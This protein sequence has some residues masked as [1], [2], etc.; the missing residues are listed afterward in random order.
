[1]TIGQTP[2]DDVIA[3]M[4]SVLE[5]TIEIVERGALDGL[6]REAIEDACEPSQGTLLVTRLRGGVEVR[7]REG[8]VTPKLQQCVTS[9][10]KRVDLI[11]VLCTGDFPPLQSDLPVLYP[12]AVLQSAVRGL[13]IQRLGVLT[14]VQAQIPDQQKRWSSVVPGVV[15]TSASPYASP[16]GVRGAARRLREAGVDAAV[17]DCIGY[18]REMKHEVRSILGQPVLAATSLLARIIAEMLA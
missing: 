4:R 12:G 8:F 1:V 17:M 16:E 5:E 3:H 14:P 7:V 10:Q 18:T 9:L 13:G 6:S 15:V 2:R 11:A